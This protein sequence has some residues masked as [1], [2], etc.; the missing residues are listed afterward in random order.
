MAR[1]FL[2]CGS[3]VFGLVLAET[4]AAAWLSWIHRLPTFPH[5]FVEPASPHDE[6]LIVVIGESSAWECHTRAGCPSAPS[7]VASYIRQ[8]RTHRFR[9]DVLAEKGAT[10]EAMHQKLASLTERPDALVVYSGHNEFLARFSLL[11]RVAYYFDEPAVRRGQAWFEQ[12]GTSLIFL[13][14]GHG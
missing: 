12:R 2:V 4:A 3:T 1:W 6:I 7:S 11:N 10:L 5:R 8:Y 13:Y 9:V 14:P